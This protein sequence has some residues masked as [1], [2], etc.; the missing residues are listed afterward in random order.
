LLEPFFLNKAIKL[1]HVSTHEAV[2][3]QGPVEIRRAKPHSGSDWDKSDW[4][5]LFKSLSSSIRTD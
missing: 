3:T 2:T 4:H 5:R 1:T